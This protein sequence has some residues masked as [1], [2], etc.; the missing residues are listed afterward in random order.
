MAMTF[1]CSACGQTISAEVPPG[2]QV[3]CPLC[4]AVV[5]VPGATPPTSPEAARLQ[6]FQ[7]QPSSQG[8]AIGALVCGVLGV[9]GCPPIGIVG[10]ILGIIA[11][12]RA[13]AHPARYGGR[14]L[15]IAGI[16]VGGAS[17]FTTALLVSIFLPSLSRAR[18]LSKRTVCMAN[19]RGLGQAMYIYAQDDPGT[20]P[21]I[22]K[23]RKAND[24][25]F[26][27]YDPATR[28]APPANDAL[29][30]PTVDLWV[31]TRDNYTTPKHFICPSSADVLDPVLDPTLYYDFAG[32]QNLSY[33][34]HFQ[35]DPNRRVLGTSSEPTFP[36]LGDANPY[37]K[38]GVP[39]S[40][41][42]ADRQSSFNGNSANHTNREGQNVLFQDGHVSFENGPDVGL[43][44]VSTL[45]NSR[46][47]DNCYTTHDAGGQ[48]DPGSA[49]P[50]A[51]GTRGVCNLGDK[52]DAC[53]IP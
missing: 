31:L 36:L 25:A 29:P 21:A 51:S 10:I 32:A 48:I 3:Q 43:S 11:L 17:I 26:L 13:S 7:P 33:A 38:G 46:Q 8:M 12:N 40:A 18:E 30:S 28:T 22:G 20:F 24:G 39:S 52:S 2:T 42:A 9:I 1:P 16:C 41:F 5:A 50:S 47:K 4:G 44:G 15:A 34:Y 53:L 19:M 23:R 6:T 27:L 35:H 37:I 14:G 49:A 45:A